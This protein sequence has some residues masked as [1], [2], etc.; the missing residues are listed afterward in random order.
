MTIKKTMQPTDVNLSKLRYPC[1][2]SPKIDGVKLVRFDGQLKGRS[3]KQYRNKHLNSMFDKP[4]YEGFEGEVIVGT[5]PYA[6]D[7]CRM[8]TSCVNSFE[9]EPD[10][11]WYVFDYVTDKTLDLTYLQR[12]DILL[13]LIRVNELENVIPVSIK[14]I[15]NEE[16]LLEEEQHYLS[17]GA[18]G[19]IIRQPYS[20]YKQGRTTV[21][22]QEV[23]RLKRFSDGESVIIGFTEEMYNGNEATKDELGRTSRSSHQDNLIGKNTLGSLLVRDCVT[24]V[25]FSIGSGFDDATRLTV[26]GNREDY[27]GMIVKYKFFDK[28]IKDLPR[29]PTFLSFRSPVDM[30]N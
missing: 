13:Y 18:E 1:L 12:M 3:F 14:P 2:L 9:G 8:T 26:W 24:G 25:E 30:E 19:I 27:L 21:N 22:S 5:N 15:Q 20:M 29:F 23:L 6:Q 16:Q 28:G 4:E 11:T 7:L 17:L 10:Y